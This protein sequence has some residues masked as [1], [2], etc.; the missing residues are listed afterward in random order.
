MRRPPEP[1]PAG[2]VA[3]ARAH[4]AAGAA[5]ILLDTA[6]G[7]HPGGTGLRAD[8]GLVAAVA[9]EVPVTLAGGLDP[10]TVGPA[11]RSAAIVGVDVA[12]GVEAPRKPGLRP[13]KDPLRVAMFVK[14]AHAARIDRPN[15]AVRPTPVHP[16]LLE[17]DERGRWGMERDF[18]GR[19]VP[20]TLMGALERLE[21]AYEAIRHDPRFWAELNELLARFAGRPTALYRADRLAAAARTEAERLVVAAGT[22][23]GRRTE[24]PGSAST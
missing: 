3:A 11:L 13:T 8:G 24:P 6:G 20:E 4:L 1:S 17:T 9:R 12:S 21:S 19:Y 7:P 18:G 23:R 2:V 5:R 15:L 16:G 14:R 10:A 22:P